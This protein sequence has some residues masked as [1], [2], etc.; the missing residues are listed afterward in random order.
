VKSKPADL[1]A[2]EAYL[3]AETPEVRAILNAIRDIVLRDAPDAIQRMSYGMPT[4]FLGGVIV[5]M[6]AFKGHIGLF[7]PVRDPA[8]MDATS[9]YRGEKGNLRF[10][11]DHPIPYN[12]IEQVVASRLADLKAAKA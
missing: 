2:V 1:E 5:H 11:L 10:P 6:G 7:P 3:A 4:F 9:A 8:L 12:L